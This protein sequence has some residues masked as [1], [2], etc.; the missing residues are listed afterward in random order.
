MKPDCPD[1]A[2]CPEPID[3]LMKHLVML[4]AGHAHVHLLSTLA[5][6]PPAG[7]KI[8]LVAPYPRQLYSGMMPGFV[9]GHYTLEDCVIPLA[10]L[11]ANSGVTWLQRSVVGL[12]ATARWLT[13]DDGSTLDFD[14]LS[15]NSGPVQDRQLVEQMMP[16]AREHALFVR[17]IEGFAALWPK[18]LAL[19]SQQALRVGVIGAGAGGIEL[20]MSVAHQLSGSSV[21]LLSGDTAV[22]AN[23]PDAVQSRL[24][25]VLKERHITLLRDRAVGVTAGAVIL[26]SGAHLACDVP[27]IAIGAQA[28]AWLQDSTLACDQQGFVV[29]DAFQRSTSHPQVFAAGDVASRIDLSLVRN[30]VH[31]VRAGPPLARNLRAVLVG[32]APSPYV[33]RVNTLNLLACGEKYAIASW[34]NWSAQ[35][36]WVWWLKDRIDRGFIRKYRQPAGQVDK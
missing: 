14:L 35:G 34:G 18:V 30:G 9:A 5:A 26:A 2:A 12:N 29:V 27:I 28:P 33:P 1:Y 36:R 24:V 31:A 10:P 21:T 11:L 25:Q 8:T 19:A 7:V 16:G 3:I 20:A 32:V 6:Q 23:Y 22:G 4:G 17:P 13:L 15:I